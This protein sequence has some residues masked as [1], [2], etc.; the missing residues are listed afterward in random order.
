MESM[1][2]LLVTV[3]VLGVVFYLLYWLVSQIPLPAPFAVVAKVLLGL[4][5]VLIL[6]GLLFGWAPFPH[7]RLR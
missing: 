3:I 4:F 2:S 6:L 5:A 1:L 7:L